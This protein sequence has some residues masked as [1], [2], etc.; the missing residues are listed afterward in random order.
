MLFNNKVIRTEE[1]AGEQVV[2]MTVPAFAKAMSGRHIDQVKSGQ[3]LPAEAGQAIPGKTSF[4]D[5]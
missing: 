3:M 5:H 4:C 1:L 2:N